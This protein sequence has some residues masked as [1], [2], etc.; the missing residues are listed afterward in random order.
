MNH[1]KIRNSK[2][3]T[4]ASSALVFGSLLSGSAYAQA[5]NDNEK[6]FTGMNVNFLVGSAPGGGYGIYAS[7]LSRHI[8]K[9]LPGKPTI[10]ARNMD[11]AGSITA[12]N[13]L[14]N[15]LPK[16]GSTFGAIFMG[17]VVEPLIGDA[18]ATLY[19][20]RKFIYIGSANRETSICVAWHTSGIETFD[21]V[22]TKELIIG[23][24]GIT[25][26]IRQYPTV[27]NN[28]LGAKFKMITGYPG[29]REAA[30]AMERGET[31]G[32]C[33]IQWTSFITSYQPWLEQKKVRI[34]AQI[35]S[36]E[37][38]AALNRLGVPTIYKYVKNEADKKTLGVIFN[39]LDFGR[40]YI[41]PPGTPPHRVEAY[42][43]AFDATMQDPDFLAEAEKLKLGID[44]VSG[45]N[46]QKIVDLIYS[47]PEAEV[48]RARAALK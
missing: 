6:F 32:I 33:G 16:D 26:S 38:D 39:Q 17:A 22:L 19:D 47:T 42:R 46:V 10:V 11:G 27:L 5:P 4:L 34:L 41:L 7:V 40:P 28:V 29:S 14:Y 44:P 20:A 12:A 43:N 15:K 35:S 24:S 36:P 3:A 9:H 30:L 8:G 21:D 2:L 23:T 13:L 48:I 31:S 37:G 18:S 45:A 1:K 25:S